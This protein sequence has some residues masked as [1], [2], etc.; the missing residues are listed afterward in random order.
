M[1]TRPAVIPART[2]MRP[3]SRPLNSEGPYIASRWLWI[4]Q[5]VSVS[6]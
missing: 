6:E 1:S 2:P 4:T 5:A 3:I